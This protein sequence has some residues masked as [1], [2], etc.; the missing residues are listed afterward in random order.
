MTEYLGPV[1]LSDAHDVAQFHS[2]SPELNAWLT[3]HA[4]GSHKGGHTRV[5]VVTESGSQAVVAYYAIAMGS[6][7]PAEATTRM[8]AG[9]GRHPVPVIVLARL[10]VDERHTGK[11][12][13]RALLLD[14]IRRSIA[15]SSDIGAR[16]II[17][18]CKDAD[19]KAFYLNTIPEFA[20]LP[21]DPMMLA[22]LLKDARASLG[23]G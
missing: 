14:A 3:K 10:A 15:A 17:V 11:R 7:T 1:H 16:A 22:L 21:H 23:V 9:G 20:E 2:S 13:G 12:L 18:H 5:A 6:V 8:S 4:R 19:A